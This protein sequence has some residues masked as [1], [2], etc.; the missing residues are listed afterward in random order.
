MPGVKK[1]VRLEEAVAVVADTYWRA[2]MALAALKPQFDDAGHGGVSTATIFAAFDKALGAPPDMPASAAKVVTADY[3][4]PF[5]AA[6]DDGADG[7]HGAG[8]RA[9]APK[10]GP[11]RRIR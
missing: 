5:L 2:R 8:R 9:T 3:K 10:C 4:V 6:R 1:V 7:V 11:A